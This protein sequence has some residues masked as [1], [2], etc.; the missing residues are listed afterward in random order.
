MLDPYYLQ[1]FCDRD[2]KNPV[3][4][5]LVASGGKERGWRMLCR[6][7]YVDDGIEPGM[8]KKKK[9]MMMMTEGKKRKEK[10]NNRLIVKKQNNAQKRHAA[11]NACTLRGSKSV[12]MDLQ[13]ED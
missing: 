11:M 3:P 13:E 2:W 4:R 10:K 8:K 12:S 6:V 7:G 5:F 9:K 1:P